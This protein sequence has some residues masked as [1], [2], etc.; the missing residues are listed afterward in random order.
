MLGYIEDL[1]V[2]S[3][4]DLAPMTQLEH[5]ELAVRRRLQKPALPHVLPPTA[6]LAAT[7]TDAPIA[8]NVCGHTMLP[9]ESCD[10]RC[11]QGAIPA[12]AL[13]AIVRPFRRLSELLVPDTPLSAAEAAEVRS[14]LPCLDDL[15]HQK[16]GQYEEMVRCRMMQRPNLTSTHLMRGKVGEPLLH[17]AIVATCV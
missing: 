13:T 12:S 9:C 1:P 16:A 15:V 14:Q 11:A 5:L 3:L 6:C 2:E 17:S 10:A 4:L 8:R 7:C